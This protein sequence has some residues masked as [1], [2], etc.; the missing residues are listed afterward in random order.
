MEIDG[1]YWIGTDDGYKQT[2]YRGKVEKL[3]IDL[4]EGRGNVEQV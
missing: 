3:G 1:E 4:G 2:F